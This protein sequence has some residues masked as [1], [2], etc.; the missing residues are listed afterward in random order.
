MRFELVRLIGRGAFGEVHLVRS[1][2]DNVEVRIQEYAL[3]SLYCAAA[4]DASL[5]TE[6]DLLKKVRHKIYSYLSA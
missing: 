3:K 1:V 2:E 4:E 5:R 6:T